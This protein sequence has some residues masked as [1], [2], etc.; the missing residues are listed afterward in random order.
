MAFS[1]AQ[2]AEVLTQALP[3]IRQYN[4]KIVVVQFGGNALINEELKQQVMED[5]ALLSLVGVRVVLIHGAGAEIGAQMKKSGK[6]V[7][8]FDGL[9]FSDS[10][11]SPMAEQ[12]LTGKVNRTL[13]N[14][15]QN[16][17]G[18]AV[19]I[20][21]IDG[22]M[23]RCKSPKEGEETALILSGADPK[24]IEALL[25]K[26][27]IPVISA[28]GLDENEQECPIAADIAATHLSAALQAQRLIIMSDV[29]GICL[30]TNNPSTLL[31][32]LSAQQ[33]CALSESGSL[34]QD[35]ISKAQ[36]C[37]TALEKGVE[38]AIIL[39]GQIPHALLM[40]LLTDEGAGTLFKK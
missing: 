8:Y 24:P 4:G 30:D 2:R 38:N 17:G 25:E 39:D 27:Y 7:V 5:I 11:D 33:Y 40:E 14:L 21:G 13:V 28:L 35:V 10:E 32:E 19:G 34:S 36:C 31:H 37:L 1:N 20:S 23:L 9:R 12:L 22:H 16:K 29:N 15:I 3:Y 18:H 6:K 26:G